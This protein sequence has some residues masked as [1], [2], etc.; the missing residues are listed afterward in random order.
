VVTLALILAAILGLAGS[1]QTP[2]HGPSA[3]HRGSV[4]EKAIW[5]PATT[6]SGSSAFPIY[7]RLGVDVLQIQLSWDTT[8]TRRPKRPTD[9]HDPAYRWPAILDRAV[10]DAPGYGIHVAVLVKGAPRWANG[11]RAPNWA[12]DNPGDYGDFLTA[13]SRRYPAVR[14]W[15]IWG[16]PNFNGGSKFQPLP[17]DSPVGPRR[18]A[19]L[20]EAAYHALKSVSRR[21]VVV[22]AMT[23]TS[24]DVRPADW[25]RW[26]RLPSGRPPDLDE[27]G[28]NP[29][30]TRFPDL[31]RTPIGPGWRDFGDL[32]TLIR[33]VRKVY[34]RVGRRPRLW[35][36]EFTISSDR[37]NRAF[38]FYVSRRKQAEW[39]SAA[40]RI[41]SHQPYVAG[42]GWLGLYDDPS[43]V[44]RG[45][46][47]GLLTYKGREKPSYDAYRRAP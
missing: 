10:R 7:K 12:P 18:Y 35:L 3:P 28:H 44:T 19:L 23:Y 26:M 32:D 42:L 8:A 5:G 6:P 29:F 17:P 4:F 30:T 22:G 45:I 16:E 40:F 41:A 31:S 13:A 38:N 2:A 43:S 15:M 20:L 9:P 24:G 46:T 33:E 14:R 47:T 27:Y 11:G 34:A 25:L 39:I 37:G 21:N 36:S 1:H